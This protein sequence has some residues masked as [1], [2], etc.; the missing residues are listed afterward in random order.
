MQLLLQ[1]YHSVVR[2]IFC[3]LHF[4][5]R[6]LQFASAFVESLGKIVV[7]NAHE[8]VMKSSGKKRER[9]AAGC[10]LT[11]TRR[12]KYGE[13]QKKKSLRK[14]KNKR[15]NGNKNRN[16][17]MPLTKFNVNSTKIKST[18]MFYLFLTGNEIQISQVE[19]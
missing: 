10:R 14:N 6:L 13:S 9:N 16:K 19:F 4:Q 18:T 8:N 15:K 5:I 7:T 11:A 3:L 2:Y 1:T 17:K 12:E